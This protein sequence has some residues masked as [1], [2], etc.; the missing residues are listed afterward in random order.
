MGADMSSRRTGV[1]VPAR[2]LS[3]SGITGFNERKRRICSR[4]TETQRGASNS[5]SRMMSCKRS[6]QART[7]DEARRV[8]DEAL[9]N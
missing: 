8:A 2:T 7:I 4:R 9:H 3:A 6:S 1:D 5:M